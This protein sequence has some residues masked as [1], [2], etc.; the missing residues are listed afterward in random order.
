MAVRNLL[1]HADITVTSQGFRSSSAFPA[2]ACLVCS[3]N[4]EFWL[5]RREFRCRIP[6]IDDGPV[7]IATSKPATGDAACKYGP[8]VPF[9]SLLVRRV[10]VLQVYCDSSSDAFAGPFILL[11]VLLQ[12]VARCP[13][14]RQN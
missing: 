11:H 12:R 3:F 4:K 2:A 7:W 9:T 8:I 14:L 6:I 1:Y 5:S 13:R 10:L